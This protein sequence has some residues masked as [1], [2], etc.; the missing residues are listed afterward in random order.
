MRFPLFFILF[1]LS[2]LG[3]NAQ[4]S[5]PVSDGNYAPWHSSDPASEHYC[6]TLPTSTAVY[7]K[8][9]LNS[10]VVSRIPVATKVRIEQVT[11]DTMKN[12]GFT[13]PWCVVSFDYYGKTQG[14]YVWGG[15]LAFVTYE[16]NEKSDSIRNGLVYL[17]GV[18]KAETEKNMWTLLV[19]V[20]R[21]HSEIASKEI[22]T[23]AEPTYFASIYRYGNLAY[24]NVLDVLEFKSYY[25]ANGYP[26]SENLLFFN[27]SDLI[28]VLET[29]DVSD[30]NTY[31]SQDFLL[32]CDKGGVQNHVVVVNNAFTMEEMEKPNGK[33]ELVTTKHKFS[34]VLYKWDGKELIKSGE[35]K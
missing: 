5:S 6:Y 8:P 17:A 7:S 30:V 21:N 1:L 27:G 3:S 31:D 32:S 10:K 34:I 11:A 4:N 24:D 19:K 20:T 35:L 23:E 18:Q 12:S 13:A 28:H 22:V 29:S 15:D 9:N 2:F 25:P 16:V 14:G 33:T 26:S